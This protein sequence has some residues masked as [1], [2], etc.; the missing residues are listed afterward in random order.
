[1]IE[2]WNMSEALRPRLG[3]S[4]AED[5]ALCEGAVGLLRSWA[6]YKDTFASMAT[7]MEDYLFNALYER[8]GPGMKAHMDDGSTRRIRTAE[9]PDLADDAMG[10]LFDS[11]RVYSVNYEA[12]HAYCME[13]GSF[14]A[15]KTL[16][17]QYESLTPVSERK[18][19]AKILRDNYPEERWKS[20]LKPDD[21]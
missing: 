1:M 7:R 18:L 11:L 21:E 13:T 14:S 15:L 2:S 10:V 17:L 3:S 9:L 4:L 12:L 19:I 16:Y 6:P 5:K 8:L 20:W